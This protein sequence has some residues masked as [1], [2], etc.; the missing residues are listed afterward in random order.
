MHLPPIA[1]LKLSYAGADPEDGRPYISELSVYEK[2]GTIVIESASDGESEIIGELAPPA[3]NNWRH[4]IEMIEWSHVGAYLAP[5]FIDAGYH[6]VAQN[7]IME[8]AENYG[9]ELIA[10]SWIDSKHTEIA[11]ALAE[12]SDEQLSAF[13]S[14]VGSF[15]SLSLVQQMMELLDSARRTGIPLKSFVRR[16]R[17]ATLETSAMQRDADTLTK[18]IREE[19]QAKRAYYEWNVGPFKKDIQQI[20]NSWRRSNAES[21]QPEGVHAGIVENY[22]VQWVTDK[23]CLPSGK[24]RITY[25]GMRRRGTD[26][27]EIK[28]DFEVDFNSFSSRE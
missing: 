10:L 13:R 17:S 7:I 16:A 11:V 25:T 26:E 23:Q 4:I 14:T 22:L 20:V 3:H 28:V 18:I 1:P 21:T 27:I 19:A 9:T 12:A 2:S 8:G 5:D 24:H 15:R 6:S